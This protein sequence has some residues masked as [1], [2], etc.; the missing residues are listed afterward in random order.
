MKSFEYIKRKFQKD[1]YKHYWN[2]TYTGKK[3]PWDVDEPEIWLAELHTQGKIKGKILDSGCGPGRNALYLASLGYDVVGSDISKSAIECGKGKARLTPA[4]QNLKFI[5]ADM[6]N[7]KK[8][9]NTFKTVVDIGC[10]H[11]I[12]STN[13]RKKYIQNLYHLCQNDAVIYLR[14]HNLL[15]YSNGKRVERVT[16]EQIRADFTLPNWEITGLEKREVD[17][18]TADGKADAWFVEMKLHKKHLREKLRF[19]V[20]LT[21]HCNL[22]CKSCSHYCPITEPKFIDIQNFE[23]DCKRLSK[24]A[25]RQTEL[26]DLCGGEP[27]LHPQLIEIMQMTRKYFDEKIRIVTNGTLLEKQS[28]EFWQTCREMKIEIEMSV[29]PVKIDIEKIAETAKK[30]GIAFHCRT[31]N[32]GKPK[33]WFHRTMDLAGK[34][35]VRQNFEICGWGN[36]YIHLKNGKLYACVRAAE[37]DRFNSFFGKHFDLSD[38]NY[39]DIYKVKNIQEILKFLSRPIP[40]CRYCRPQEQQIVEWGNSKKEKEEWI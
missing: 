21:D 35:N 20:D 2:K 3:L 32:A 18:L 14:A 1:G 33:L 40:F 30:Q 22:N 28:P 8:Y 38:K 7:F 24:L 31:E 11:S 23:R 10:Y 17:L 25:S 19:Q 34:Q 5:V 39:I 37:A 29:Y 13:D 27:L 15:K 6:R 36:T 9:R 4:P 26:I 16:E 12:Y